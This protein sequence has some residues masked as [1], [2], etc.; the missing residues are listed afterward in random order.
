MKTNEAQLKAI[1]KYNKDKTKTYI[2][3]LNKVTDKDLIELLDN[4]DNKQGF[5]K[6]L[7]R[8]YNDGA[9]RYPYSEIL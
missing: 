2:I 5:I 7:L 6:G 8:A 1:A 9:I 4:Q 3:R